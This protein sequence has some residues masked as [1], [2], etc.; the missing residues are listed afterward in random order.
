MAI[1]VP[2]PFVKPT[3]RLARPICDADGRVVAGTGTALDDHLV[4]ALRKMAIQTVPVVESA[5][6]ANWERTKPLRDELLELEQRLDREP[7]GEAL[8]ALRAAITRHLCKRALRLEQE[9]GF[10]AGRPTRDPAA[11][12]GAAGKSER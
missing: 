5:D 11:S 3:M 6:L 1:R 8:M 12:P 4:R 9:P 7:A 2:L 10:A